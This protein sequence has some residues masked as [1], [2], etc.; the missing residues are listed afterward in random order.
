MRVRGLYLTIR[1]V[2]VGYDAKRLGLGHRLT[3]MRT[4]GRGEVDHIGILVLTW[5][6][7]CSRV[8]M[9]PPT[10]KGRWVLRRIL[11]EIDKVLGMHAQTCPLWRSRTRAIF[12]R[13]SRTRCGR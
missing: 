10:D 8:S 13:R 3:N 1:H 12:R 6:C 9:A 7:S 11:R 4:A 2:S 5:H